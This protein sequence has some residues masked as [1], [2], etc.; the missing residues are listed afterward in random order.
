LRRVRGESDVVLS[1]Q[2]RHICD[3]FNAVSDSQLSRAKRRS[4][5]IVDRTEVDRDA[6]QRSVH[7][8]EYAAVIA[9]VLK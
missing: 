9:A 8:N 7:S 3:Q 1:Y 5:D 2:L 4:G 6:E